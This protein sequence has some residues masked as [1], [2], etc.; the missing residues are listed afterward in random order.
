MNYKDG[1]INQNF[2]SHGFR[3][4]RRSSLLC[5]S[6]VATRIA[7]LRQAFVRFGRVPDYPMR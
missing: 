7:R 5:R 3:R 6:A 1:N 4:G 2:M